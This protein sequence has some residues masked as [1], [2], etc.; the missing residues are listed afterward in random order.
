VRPLDIKYVRSSFLSS[1]GASTRQSNTFAAGLRLPL[2]TIFREE[3]PTEGAC[4]PN[5]ARSSLQPGGAIFPAGWMLNCC[6]LVVLE[7]LLLAILGPILKGILIP[8]AVVSCFTKNGTPSSFICRASP[9]PI[10]KFVCRAPGPLQLPTI[11]PMDSCQV[12]IGAL[13]EQ[14]SIERNTDVRWNLAQLIRCGSTGES[15]QPKHQA[16]YWQAMKQFVVT[17][18]LC[19]LR[20]Y[21]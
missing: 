16:R 12:C 9:E 14:S 15:S 4:T 21:W 19:S 5:L 10:L 18:S 11:T 2:L 7:I 13:L 8:P 17:D 1:G 6:A 20:K 3:N